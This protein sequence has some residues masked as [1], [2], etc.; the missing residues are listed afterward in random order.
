MSG[1]RKAGSCLTRL[2]DDSFHIVS[3][4]YRFHGDVEAQSETFTFMLMSHFSAYSA[5]LLFY[6]RAISL[7]E[8]NHLAMID[9]MYNS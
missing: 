2:C 6:M 7:L 1:S 9:Q 8:T 3:R 4:I 5:F